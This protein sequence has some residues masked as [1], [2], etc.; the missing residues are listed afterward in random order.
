MAK[1]TEATKEVAK[2][3]DIKA[4]ANGSVLVGDIFDKT[5]KF[6]HNGEDCT[7]DI[8][9]KQLPFAVT[10]PLFTRLH[11]GENVVAEWASQALVDDDGKTYLTKEQ[12]SENFTQALAG[13]VFDAILGIERPVLDDTGKSD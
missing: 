9:I 13:A 6:K 12:V 3:F 8:R 1:K 7:V 2:A 11:K 4:I 5:V 10:E